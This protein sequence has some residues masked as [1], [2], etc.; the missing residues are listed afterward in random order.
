MLQLP[1]RWRDS[2][3]VS[4]TIKGLVCSN[5]VENGRSECDSHHVRE[6]VMEATYKA[7]ITSMTKNMNRVIDVVTEGAML[8]MQP[9]NAE[10]LAAVERDIVYT[11][12]QALA[13]HKKKVAHQISEDEYTAAIQR[14]GKRMEELEAQQKDLQAA[15]NRFNEVKAWLDAFRQCVTNDAISTNDTVLM[16]ALVERIIVWDDHI[17]VVFKCGGSIEQ[18]Y[19]R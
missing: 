6:D 11:Q 14:C 18:K 10:K 13:L 8:S 19:V 9:K 2:N 17:E 4:S 15:E 1:L 5:R 3:L 7:A 12:E 16:K